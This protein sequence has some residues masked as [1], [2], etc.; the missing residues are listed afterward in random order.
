MG[1]YGSPDVGNLYTEKKIKK[2]KEEGKKPQTNIWI[3]IVMITMNVITMLT[4]GISS[5]FLL[6]FLILD[7]VTLLVISIISLALNLI[8]KRKINNDLKFIGIS[9][10]ASLILML[11]L[12]TL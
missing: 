2:T 3:W 8:N 1:L 11:M 6:S 4:A 5:Q 12:G 7:T 9:I 10:V